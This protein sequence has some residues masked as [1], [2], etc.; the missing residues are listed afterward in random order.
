MRKGWF[1]LP[2][3][4]GDRNLEDQ[5]KGLDIALLEAR[6]KR[7]VDL[8]CAEGLIAR[9]F[10]EAGASSVQG[11]DSVA[12]H[13]ATGRKMMGAS[14]VALEQGDLNNRPLRK[15]IS[16]MQFD[17]ALLLAILH[18]LREPAK[19]LAAV[20]QAAPA[21]IV[22]RLPPQTAPVIVDARS[23]RRP[24]NVQT[25]LERHGYRLDSIARGHFD[26][27]MGYFRNG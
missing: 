13:I 4:I 16:G 24:C 3:Q 27:W 17:I 20:A 21:L 5:L 7:V 25:E 6:G 26:E 9:R 1:N 18:K 10:A 15:H 2:G 12:G 8:G 14:P 22:V 19:L 11:F 23:G